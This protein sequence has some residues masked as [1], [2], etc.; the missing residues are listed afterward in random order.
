MNSRL[1]GSGD[2]YLRE[3]S[4]VF[5]WETPGVGRPGLVPR[6][7]PAGWQ[8]IDEQLKISCPVILNKKKAGCSAFGSYLF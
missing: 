4:H 8:E 5:S 2:G 7:C 3:V 1:L 6:K